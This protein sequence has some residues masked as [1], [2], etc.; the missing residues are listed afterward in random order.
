ERA[1]TRSSGGRRAHRGETAT[2]AGRGPAPLRLPAQRPG[3][4]CSR[5]RATRALRRGHR[6]RPRARGGLPQRAAAGQDRRPGAVAE[7]LLT[8][9][10]HGVDARAARGRTGPAGAGDRRRNGL[11]RGAA[12]PARGPGRNGDDDR[13]RS[14]A[15]TAGA[16]GSA[17]GRI[18]RAGGRRRRTRR[19]HGRRPVRPHHRDRERRGD[20]ERV[21][22]PARP[23]RPPA[24]PAAPRLR[25]AWTG[26][27]G[28]RA[29]RRSRRIG[30]HDVGRLHAAARRGRRAGSL[31][32]P[33]GQRV[34]HR[35]VPPARPDHRP[36]AGAP[37]RGGTPAAARPGA[38]RPA[39]AGARRTPGDA[40]AGTAEPVAAPAD[41]RSRDPSHRAVPGRSTGPRAHVTRR[42]RHRG[43]LGARPP[44]DPR[45][46]PRRAAPLPARLLAHRHLRRRRHGRR[47]RAD[48]GGVASAHPLRAH[49]AADRGA[50]LERGVQRRSPAGVGATTA[51]L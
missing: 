24:A 39:V 43:R 45:Q 11:Q 35:R 37:L 26:D 28:A 13:H 30:R 32:G 3:G 51:E 22:R 6:G 38:R 5:Q 2:P 17:A 42:P 47:A 25:G 21:A 46:R 9:V 36:R 50:P 1:P 31:S 40:L 20:P 44:H 14:R 19:L 48:R 7:L 8:A 49:A 29:A 16:T 23:G 27:P 12:A 34:D 18:P 4:R 15:G 33:R 41:A 10:D